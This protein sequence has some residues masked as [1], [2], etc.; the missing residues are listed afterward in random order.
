MLLVNCGTAT[1]VYDPATGALRAHYTTHGDASC[2]TDSPYYFTEWLVPPGSSVAHLTIMAV[3]TGAVVW[4]TPVTQ[5]SPCALSGDRLMIAPP[6]ETGPGVTEFDVAQPRRQAF[7]TS[8]NV[9]WSFGPSGYVAMCDDNDDLIGIGP[10]GQLAWKSDAACEGDDTGF[11]F[12]RSTVDLDSGADV[13]IV[14]GAFLGAFSPFPPIGAC[15]IGRT[16]S[17]P[18]VFGTAHTPASG[19]C[20]GPGTESMFLGPYGVSPWLTAAAPAFALEFSLRAIAVER[21]GV[22][23]STQDIQA[24][25]GARRDSLDHAGRH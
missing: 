25:D 15:C 2:T 20:P 1:S 23:C 6:L 13:D 4:R 24:W 21:A 22:S 3:R 17:G 18:F 8:S 9:V 19:Q 7:T 10:S 11:S 14:T 5:Q 16:Y 12:E